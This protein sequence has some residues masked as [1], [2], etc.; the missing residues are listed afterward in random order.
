MIWQGVIGLIHFKYRGE[1]VGKGR[2]RVTRQGGHIHTYTPEKTRMFEEAIRFELL[3]S[4]CE[5]IPIYDV[6][7]PLKA[8]I[9]IG[10][11]V[12]TSYSNKKRKEC[13]EGRIAPT[14]KPDVDNILKSIF[15]ALCGFAMADDN[16]IVEIVAEKLYTEE[17]YVEVTI[18]R[19]DEAE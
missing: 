4:T 2:P 12:P 5:A 13:L 11:R 7:T 14:K 3:A 6:G 17:P 8:K 10:T 15:D 18:A 9:K 1:A 16:Q 19:K